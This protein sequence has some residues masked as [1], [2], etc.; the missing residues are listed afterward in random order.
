MLEKAERKVNTVM[1]EVKKSADKV[2]VGK[3]IWKLMC[4]PSI[5]TG[6]AVV[7]TSPHFLF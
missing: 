6:R 3:A 2:I 4:M 1:A 5:L 7:P